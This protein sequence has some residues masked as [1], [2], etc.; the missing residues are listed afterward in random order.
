VFELRNPLSRVPLVTPE[1][2][3]IS[4][5]DNHGIQFAKYYLLPFLSFQDRSSMRRTCKVMKN[6]IPG[7]RYV[8]CNVLSNPTQARFE[9]NTGFAESRGDPEKGGDSSEVQFHLQSGVRAIVG[10][11]DAYAALKQNGNVV[12]W[13]NTLMGGIEQLPHVFSQI[14]SNVKQ[15]HSTSGAFAVLKNNGSVFAW[16]HLLYGGSFSNVASDLISGVQNITSTS[17]E[18]AVLKTD[19]S[20]V[21]WGLSTFRGDFDGVFP[22]VFYELQSNVT[23]IV[24]TVYLFAALKT[25]GRV[26]I[27]GYD[28]VKNPVTIIRENIIEIQG[29][30][31]HFCVTQQDGSKI[32]CP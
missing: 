2:S 5:L 9:I 25:S 12:T 11:S 30:E 15:I 32:Q 7:P 31:S 16:G 3:L 24:S 23:Q 4:I 26:V 28:S 20:V 29:G 21:T 22:G 14:Q 8:Y 18:F 6:F 1:N 10:N 13:G 27:W 17:T 19:G